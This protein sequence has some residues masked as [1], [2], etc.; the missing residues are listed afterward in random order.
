MD[1][2]QLFLFVCLVHDGVIVSFR[3]SLRDQPAFKGGKH[4]PHAKND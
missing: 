2:P 3:A 1:F 4:R